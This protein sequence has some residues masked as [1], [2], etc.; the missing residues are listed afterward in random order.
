MKTPAYVMHDDVRWHVDSVELVDGIEGFNLS[1]RNPASGKVTTVFAWSS[2]CEPWVKTTP[3]TRKIKDSDFVLEFD[4]RVMT[5]RKVRSPTRFP[6]SLQ[7][8]YHQAAK[9]VAMAARL[10]KLKAKGKRLSNRSKR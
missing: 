10:A 2:N 4:G 8:V 6:V 9:S 3:N 1:R 5:I 7:A